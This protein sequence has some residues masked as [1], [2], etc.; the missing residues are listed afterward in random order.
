MDYS[1]T[2]AE[3]RFLLG[4]MIKASHLDWKVIVDFLRHHRVQPDWLSMQIPP[5]RNMNQCLRAAEVMLD[6]P[7]H[8]PQLLGPSPPGMGPDP[9]TKRKPDAAAA[10]AAAAPRLH[11][12]P[13]NH[14]NNNNNNN[15]PRKRQAI[16]PS[17]LK[18]SP[19]G[20]LYPSRSFGPGYTLTTGRSL[21][22]PS[23]AT[24]AQPNGYAPALAGPTGPI[25]TPPVLPSRRKRGRP[26]KADM[27]ARARER[28]ARAGGGGYA[29]IKAAPVAIAPSPAPGVAPGYQALSARGVLRGNGT[30]P[31]AVAA[32]TKAVPPNWEPAAA[33]GKETGA[34][35][36]GDGPVVKPAGG[37]AGVNGASGGE[38]GPARQEREADAPRTESP[39]SVAS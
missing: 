1:F 2:E 22:P 16:L 8:P 14:K 6:A 35:G 21:A 24:A 26:S 7:M 19:N 9:G 5:G 12:D 28:G 11:D 31:A 3:K 38:G 30:P 17:P 23:P 10:A 34:Q 25:A 39:V 33:E 32:Q 29:P 13:R 27:E 18:P 20:G 36:G 37:A 15:D 4:E